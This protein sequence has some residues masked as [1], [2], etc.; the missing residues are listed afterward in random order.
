MSLNT[1]ILVYTLLF[2][3]GY[4]IFGLFFYGMF[5]D[6]NKQKQDDI[7]LLAFFLW[8]LFLFFLILAL[9]ASCVNLIFKTTF[10]ITSKV[11]VFIAKIIISLGERVGQFLAS[12]FPD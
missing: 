10:K 1:G 5:K 2:V 11:V 9:V 7:S 12:I 8:P 3:L 4:A 6:P